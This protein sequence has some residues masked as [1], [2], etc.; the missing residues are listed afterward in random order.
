MVSDAGGL[1]GECVELK[2]CF[3][4]GCEGIGEGGGGREMLKP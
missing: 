1:G 3:L 4:L 2:V